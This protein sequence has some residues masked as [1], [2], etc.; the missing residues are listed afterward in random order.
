GPF[1]PWPGSAPSCHRR[2]TAR[3]S[4]H[5]ARSA[6]A[7]VA[8]PIDAFPPVSLALP[9]QR[10]MLAELLEQDHGQKVRSGEA[11]RRDVERRRRL[12]DRL[13][14]PAREPLPHRLDHLPLTWDY[15]QCLGDVLPQLRQFRR[16]A[17]GTAFRRRDDDAL[18]RQMVG[19]WFAGRPLA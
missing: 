3:Q 5:G 1:Y 8:G 7:A 9:V 2:A 6:P 19:E 4:G 17:A 16:P 18:A 13:A 11:P 10:L 12:R 14:V 15:L